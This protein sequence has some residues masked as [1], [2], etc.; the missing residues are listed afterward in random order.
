MSN[1]ITALSFPLII[2]NSLGGIVALIW[3]GIK[4]EWSLILYGIVAGF[5]AGIVFSFVLLPQIGC[6]LLAMK[7]VDMKNKFFHFIAHILCI[8]GEVYSII[9]ITIWVYVVFTYSYLLIDSPIVQEVELP[10]LLWAYCI[11]IG[12]LSYMASKEGFDSGYSAS[13]TVT[14]F[15]S[16]GCVFI[17]TALYFFDS[18]L[19]KTLFYFCGIMLGSLIM[20][21]YARFAIL[22]EHVRLKNLDN[23][24]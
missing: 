20:N 1:L 21:A 2:L 23:N 3:L 24:Y 18:S 13:Y 16:I 14:F 15:T 12:H 7:L 5:L 19:P 11:V 6:S 22:K 9:I 10:V 8:I 17:M 4:G